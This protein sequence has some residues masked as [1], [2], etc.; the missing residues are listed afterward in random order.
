[1]T[2]ARQRGGGPRAERGKGLGHGMALRKRG[3]PG[4]NSKRG[5]SGAGKRTL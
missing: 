5:A 2:H 3:P 4:S 1:M